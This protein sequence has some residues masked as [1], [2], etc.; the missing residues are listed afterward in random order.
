MCDYATVESCVFA[1]KEK[2]GSVLFGIEGVWCMACGGP[3]MMK[4][5]GVVEEGLA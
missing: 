1:S 5:C 2:I 4:K 3:E